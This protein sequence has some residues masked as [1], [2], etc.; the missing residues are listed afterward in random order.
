[1][2]ICACSVSVAYLGVLFFI[3][4]GLGVSCGHDLPAVVCLRPCAAVTWPLVAPMPS[5]ARTASVLSL[6]HLS[7]I[8]LGAEAAGCCEMVVTGC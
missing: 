2:L 5:C 8:C 3:E 1:M 4:L 6:Q 7:I